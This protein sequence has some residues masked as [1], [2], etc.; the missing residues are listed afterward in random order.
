[1]V[2]RQ[3]SESSDF[4]LIHVLVDV[5]HSINSSTVVLLLLDFYHAVDIILRGECYFVGMILFSNFIFRLLY[6]IR[7]YAHNFIERLCN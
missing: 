5:A 7:F 1:M 4:R 6:A 3:R 2:N